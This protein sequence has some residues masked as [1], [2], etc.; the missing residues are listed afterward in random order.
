MNAHQIFKH[1]HF[2]SLVIYGVLLFHYDAFVIHET[3]FK[4]NFL[5][6]YDSQQF[7]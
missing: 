3:Y 2:L 4:E 5:L 7:G 6:S 1:G